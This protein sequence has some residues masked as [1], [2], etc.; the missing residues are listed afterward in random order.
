MSPADLSAHVAVLAP[1]YEQVSCESVWAA[2]SNARFRWPVSDSAGV[3]ASPRAGIRASVP[4]RAVLQRF[5]MQP[6]RVKRKLV[7][8]AELR[9]ETELERGT[10]TGLMIPV[11]VTP[12]CAALGA[13]TATPVPC[14]TWLQ[15]HLRCKAGLHDP[16]SHRIESRLSGSTD[17][18][19]LPCA[20]KCC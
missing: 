8:V 9:R 17:I 6:V 4:L 15:P 7:A 16:M 12:I 11:D 18:A 19:W 2:P 14:C 10:R 3:A 13:E 5:T 1:D 20:G